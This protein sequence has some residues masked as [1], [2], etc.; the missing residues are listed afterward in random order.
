MTR[1]CEG[2]PLLPLRSGKERVHDQADDEE[3]DRV[4]QKARRDLKPQR[5]HRPLRH[6]APVEPGEDD[7]DD[8]EGDS[9]RDVLGDGFHR[10][11]LRWHWK[12]FSNNRPIS[13][14]LFS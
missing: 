9:L 6:E 1:P 2:L 5:P 13:V 12:D 14:Y 8:A 4:D 10:W 11:S 3:N 7:H